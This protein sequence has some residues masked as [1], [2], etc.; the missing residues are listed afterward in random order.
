MRLLNWHFADLEYAYASP[1][2]GVSLGGWDQDSG[3]EFEGR[4]SQIIGGYSQMVRGLWKYPS[5]LDV[6]LNKQVKHVHWNKS[7][8]KGAAPG[9][10]EFTDST[11]FNPDLIVTTLPL[12]VYHWESE[13]MFQPKL[14]DWKLDALF[15]IEHGVLNKVGFSIRT[16][17]TEY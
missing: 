13:K 11:S 1:L 15:R 5:Q 6:R 7:L 17:A 4:H 3:N 16:K 2:H 9:R 10:L 8:E 12:G 14:P